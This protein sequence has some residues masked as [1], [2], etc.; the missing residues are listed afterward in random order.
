M[1]QTRRWRFRLLMLTALI[2][3][4]P[5]LGC[6]SSSNTDRG[7]VT[8]GALGAVAGGLL[9][10]RG[11]G[12]G[13][14]L[15]GGTIGAVA[16]GLTGAAVDNSEKKMAVR[17][18]NQRS[19]A[20]QDIVALTASGSSDAVIISQIGNGGC[21]YNL[22]ADEVIYLQN[23]GVREPVIRYMQATGG[24]VPYGVQPVYIVEPPPPVGFG[25]RVGI[26]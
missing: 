14:A 16:G 9:A 7:I 24:V 26:R 11:H 23:N 6:A 19:L 15:V 25:V 18:A 10:G 8:G 21:A 4:L 17:Q 3:V 1:I 5:M 20:L 13:G 2:P 22:R 12:L